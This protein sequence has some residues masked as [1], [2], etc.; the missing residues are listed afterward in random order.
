MVEQRVEGGYLYLFA[1][2]RPSWALELM[3][4]KPGGKQ[5]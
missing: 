3:S 4:Q 2:V 5:A 1:Y